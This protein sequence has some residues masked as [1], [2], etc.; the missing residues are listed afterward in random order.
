MRSQDRRSRFPPVP[1]ARRNRRRSH[2]WYYKAGHGTSGIQ[3]F[4]LRDDGR[5]K[6][7]LG[8]SDNADLREIEFE[9]AFV[10]SISLGSDRGEPE[11]RLTSRGRLWKG[12]QSLWR[13]KRK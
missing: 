4:E 12:W 8:S 2:K 3:K 6:I 5:F 9:E 7:Q 1:F 13:W 11:M 10:L